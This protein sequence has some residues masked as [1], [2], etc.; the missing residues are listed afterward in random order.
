MTRSD[1]TA[2]RERDAREAEARAAVVRACRH[3]SAAGLSPG[4]SG[5]VSVR[6]GSR[7]IATPT[8]SSLRSVTEEQLAA[9]PADQEGAPRPT[10]ELPL[11]AAMY[12]AHPDA[13]AVVHL[14]SPYATAVACL[15]ATE[16]GFAQLPPLTPY[17]V[18]RLGDVPLVPYARPGSAELAVGVSAAAP[19]HPALLLANHGPVV[20]AGTLDGAIDLVEE[21][22]TAAQLTLLL[23]QAPAVPLDA[24]A[25][26]ALT[27]PGR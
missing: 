6:V 17:R 7:I 21:L 24:A 25:I 15:P 19:G 22:E 18:M 27:P 1:D 2:L 8:G 20:A 10:K 12:A 11:H 9:T 14:H 13:T 16:G 5:N 4:S 3:L 26:A 23:Q